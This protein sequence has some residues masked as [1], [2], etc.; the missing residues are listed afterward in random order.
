MAAVYEKLGIRFFFPEDWD[1]DESEAL[2]GNNMVSVYSP[3]GAFWS[4]IVHPPGLEPED[5]LD[6]ALEAMRQEY[7][8]LDAEPFCD[9]IQ[10]HEIVGSDLNFYCLDLTNSALVRAFGTSR[11]TYLVLC[12][13]DDREFERVGA[14][15]EAMTHSL[16]DPTASSDGFD[17]LQRG[18]TAGEPEIG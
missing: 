7:P 4:V 16:L 14:V 3:L 5:L 6:A 17:Q 8:E 18:V 9:V 15:F 12:Q 13:A 11:G 2:D 10:G 1:L